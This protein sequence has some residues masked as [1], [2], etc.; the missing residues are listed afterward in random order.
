MST[1]RVIYEIALSKTY[2]IKGSQLA[3]N[4]SKYKT[5]S[6]SLV[7]ISLLNIRSSSDLLISFEI[8]EE[9]VI[10]YFLVL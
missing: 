2:R 10:V 7:S 8:V 9:A 4:F 1:P 3:E 5:S 6:A